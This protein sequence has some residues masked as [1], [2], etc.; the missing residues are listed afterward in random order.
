ME[1]LY[2]ARNGPTRSLV[3][4]ASQRLLLAVHEF[5]ILAKNA[6]DKT[7]TRVCKPCCWTVVVPETHRNDR[8]YSIRK[9]RL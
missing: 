2:P 3:A 1:K 6:V 4:R 9:L 8:S 7:S 5:H